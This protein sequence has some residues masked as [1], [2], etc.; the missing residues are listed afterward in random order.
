MVVLAVT[1]FP[2]SHSHSLSI[3]FRFFVLLLGE[4]WN[5]K[6]TNISTIEYSI[7]KKLSTKIIG[8]ENSFGTVGY[9]IRYRHKE[10]SLIKHEIIKS[11]QIDALLSR[12]RFQFLCQKHIPTWIDIW[13]APS[14]RC[15]N[16]N[17]CLFIPR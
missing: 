8:N 1:H 4:M 17:L 3:T 16:L 10:Y 12:S 5:K 11:T 6:K 7:G 2:F 9:Q 13:F 14:K 15:M